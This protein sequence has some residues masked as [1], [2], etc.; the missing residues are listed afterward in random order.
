[1]I[2]LDVFSAVLCWTNHGF[3]GFRFLVWSDVLIMAETKDGRV[4][5]A[6]KFRWLRRD[7]LASTLRTSLETTYGMTQT[8]PWITGYLQSQL[9]LCLTL[10][11]PRVLLARDSLVQL[12]ESLCIGDAVLLISILSSSC[13][14]TA[15]SMFC[16]TVKKTVTPGYL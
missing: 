15:T 8:H 6:F 1:M 3:G 13:W 5:A 7:N 2:S 4:P 16:K 11:C 14:Q 10:C 12:G 9:L